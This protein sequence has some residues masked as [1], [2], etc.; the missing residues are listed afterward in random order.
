MKSKKQIDKERTETRRNTISLLHTVFS[1]LKNIVPQLSI[2]ATL[3]QNY[4]TNKAYAL[5]RSKD[6]LF[7]LF[8]EAMRKLGLDKSVKLG[9]NPDGTT[10]TAM[11]T[12]RTLELYDNS[13]NFF[14]SIST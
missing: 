13:L 9:V 6:N 11:Y 10:M 2:I 1:V 5:S 7:Q 4:K 3:I 14:L 8:K 12:V